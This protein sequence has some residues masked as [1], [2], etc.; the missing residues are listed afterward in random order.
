VAKAKKNKNGKHSA[1][2]PTIIDLYC[3]SIEQ[4][5]TDQDSFFEEGIYCFRSTALL[6][7]RCQETLMI[8]IQTPFKN[9]ET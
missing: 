7:L 2:E 5:I 6:K 1:L 8:G 4:G 3:F 9:I